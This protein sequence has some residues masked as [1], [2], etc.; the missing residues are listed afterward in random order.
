MAR[1]ADKDPLTFTILTQPAHGMLGGTAPN[2]T[3]TPRLGFT[4]Q[5]SFTFNVNDGDQGSAPATVNLTVLANLTPYF[6]TDPT[7]TTQATWHVAYSATL[8]GKATDPNPGDRASLVFSKEGGPN[9][10]KVSS[11]GILTG[12]PE[13]SGKQS[14]AIRITDKHGA[15]VVGELNITVVGNPMGD[16]IFVDGSAKGAGDGTCWKDAYTTIKKAFTDT[17]AA[18][19]PIWV[20]EG[21]YHETLALFSGC[22]IYGG[23]SK[24]EVK[25]WHRNVSANPT[26]IDVSTLDAALRYHAIKATYVSN[27]L[28]DGLTLT[29]GFA[30]GASWE[31]CG[32]GLYIAN[33][34]SPFTVSNCTFRGNQAAST[35]GGAF[36]MASSPTFDHCTFAYNTAVQGGGLRLETS[37]SPTIAD[38]TFRGNI[39]TNYGGGTS[40]SNSTFNLTFTRCRFLNNK[41]GYSGGGACLT[42]GSRYTFDDCL[43][44]GNLS[45]Y[46]GAALSMWHDNIVANLNRCVFAGNHMVNVNDSNQLGPALYNFNCQDTIVA[47]NCLFTGNKSWRDGVFNITGKTGL[48]TTARFEN[49]NFTGNDTVGD[50]MVGN[51]T[52]AAVVF[53]NC[54]MANNWN[55]ANRGDGAVFRLGTECAGT[56]W[57]RCLFYNNQKT[58]IAPGVDDRILYDGVSAYYTAETM[59]AGYVAGGVNR[60]FTGSGALFAMDRKTPG[61]WDAQSEDATQIQITLTDN[62]AAWVPG[63]LVGKLI[64]VNAS[65]FTNDGSDLRG[66]GV[67]LA[68]TR[69]TVTVNCV[70]TDYG[71]S[72][73]LVGVGYK[74]F[75]EFP[76]LKSQ[77]IDAGQPYATSPAGDFRSAPRPRDGDG[78]GSAL[79]DIGAYE[80]DLKTLKS[81]AGRAWLKY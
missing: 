55:T 77:A 48:N 78:N 62:Q 18:T 15:S 35:G 27:V 6:L 39:V 30:N 72:G 47:T 43:F 26:I 28:L 25:T 8:A 67:A 80:M 12:T 2:L 79:L 3:Y 33:C 4:G 36:A 44:S 41:T 23:F 75:D 68:N 22:R 16:V 70:L 51:I 81:A 50:Q 64:L 40:N 19:V 20:A 13:G 37:G 1:T 32:G 38:C 31:A 5:D 59:P 66:V 11:A 17:R 53:N 42:M 65:P 7:S 60:N 9:W 21:T 46:R 71:V 34:T 74:F 69:N 14:F 54:L 49:C 29:G 52:Y 76:Y 73:N 63:S 56:Q 61:V 24:Y 10:L 57:N 45:G 58:Q